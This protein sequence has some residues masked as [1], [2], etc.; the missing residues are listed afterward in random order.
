MRYAACSALVVRSA[1]QGAGAEP[2]S[3]VTLRI[4]AAHDHSEAS[5][6]A[7][8]QLSSLVLGERAISDRACA[9]LGLPNGNYPNPVTRMAQQETQGE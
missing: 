9:G 4:L 8:R 5:H 7:I 6:A 2:L 3:D 1:E